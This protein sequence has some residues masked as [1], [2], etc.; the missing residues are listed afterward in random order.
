[1][2]YPDYG[3][4]VLKGCSETALIGKYENF[5]VRA[6]FLS[7]LNTI[8]LQSLHVSIHGISKLGLNA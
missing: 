8:Y 3:Y 2:R 7:L 4:R 1:M 6:V 5:P